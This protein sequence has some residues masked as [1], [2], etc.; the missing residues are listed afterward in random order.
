MITSRAFIYR[1]L[2]CISLLVSVLFG[3]ND[4]YALES[5]PVNGEFSS[6]TLIAGKLDT[7]ENGSATL[8]AALRLRLK[9]G[10][11]TYWR[12]AGDA[13]FPLTAEA[14][15]EAIN[16]GAIKLHWPY[17]ARYVEEWGLESF[18]FKQQ[19]MLPIS[20][21]IPDTKTLSLISLKVN[22]AVCSD[23]CISEEN[24]IRLSLPTSYKPDNASLFLIR[25]AEKFVPHENGYKN[26]QIQPPVIKSENKPDGKGI[27]QV[28][29]NTNSRLGLPELFVEG[30]AGLRSPKANLSF[31]K[32]R[33]QVVFEIPYEIAL[34]AKTL[35]G[36]K[37]TFTFA[38][39]KLAVEANYNA[40][41]T[42]PDTTS[43]Y[44][45]PEPPEAN[46][47]VPNNVPSPL[48]SASS[49]SPSLLFIAA[50]AVL[51]GLI[52][53]IMPCVLPV[54]SIKLLCVVQHGGRNQREIRL[55]FLASSLGIITFFL[56]LAIITISIKETGMAVGW[57]FHFQSPVFIGFLFILTL[58]F[59]TNLL[60]KFEIR[61]PGWLNTHIYEASASGTLKRHHLLGDYATGIFAALMATPCSAPFLGTA[62]G[63]ALARGTLEIAVIFLALGL[64]L[65][66]PYLMAACIP[67]LA[68]RLPKPG[69]WMVRVK[70]VMGGLML[71]S[72]LWLGWVLVEQLTPNQAA[73]TETS[74]A[75]L[76]QPFDEAKIP[77]LVK[78]GK[79]VFVDITADWCLTC[80]FNK[81]RV[82]NNA[83][84]Q[85]MLTEPNVIAMQGDMTRPNPALQA[86]LKKN[87]RYGIPFNI[88]YSPAHPEG[89]LLPELLT[90]DAVKAAV[91]QKEGA[92][93][94]AD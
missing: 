46:N 12:S 28:T 94:I 17:P 78:E 71:L 67:S 11:K 70:Q 13:G 73:V 30:P 32:D 15:E 29:V 9:N 62:V 47:N 69:M 35:K 45:E 39:G 89:L 20:I 90:I 48:S 18:A 56:V 77:S 42:A 93:A 33:K 49:S 23:I 91:T 63:F 55:S 2:L 52:L 27:L 57:G 83:E 50:I 44:A 82:L 41:S 68:M 81:L 59:A 38:E 60:G 8:H 43:P 72:S 88:A 24:K 84:I 5:K 53:N 4:S 58:L 64:G 6:L 14:T 54:L 26:V 66:L 75:S 19:L 92:K 87:G 10:W 34:P 3:A 40:D 7:H 21:E 80:K 16:I 36:A 31:S 86:Y 65:A 25:T 61:L 51:G 74:K 1:F 85:A 76:W 79:T 22:Y 37:L